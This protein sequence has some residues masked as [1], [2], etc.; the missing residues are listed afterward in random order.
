MC[1]VFFIWMSLP[2][3]DGRA[4]PTARDGL[5]CRR[6]RRREA[7]YREWPGRS[8]SRSLAPAVSGE[9]ALVGGEVAHTRVDDAERPDES[10]VGRGDRFLRRPS[11][12]LLESVAKNLGLRNASP[13]SESGQA[14]R[15]PLGDLQRQD[16]HEFSVLPRVTG[17]N[18]VGPPSARV[19]SSPALSCCLA[20]AGGSALRGDTALGRVTGL[21]ALTLRRQLDLG[22]WR[23]SARPRRR[24][25][26]I[27]HA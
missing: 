20:M 16:G 2:Y 27:G 22:V 3:R 12:R 10:V 7:R 11:E 17:V 5:R 14:S 8:P 24:G 19:H 9:V 21:A 15:R 4:N 13:G 1:S 23:V 26:A 6:G 18:T 25:I